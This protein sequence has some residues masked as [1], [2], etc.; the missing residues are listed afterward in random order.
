[1][2]NELPEA[3]VLFDPQTYSEPS[4]LTSEQCEELANTSVRALRTWFAAH[5]PDTLTPLLILAERSGVAAHRTDQSML[6]ILQRMVQKREHFLAVESGGVEGASFWKST[7]S[8]LPGFCGVPLWRLAGA[9]DVCH[10]WP[11][12]RNHLRLR[13][14]PAGAEAA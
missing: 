14:L 7:V 3:H 4:A 1:M 8:A 9:S 6:A 13:H 2:E 5:A 10:G 12:R 11:V